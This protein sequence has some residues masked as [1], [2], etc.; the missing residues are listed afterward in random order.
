VYLSSQDDPEVEL[1]HSPSAKPP[2]HGTN[3]ISGAPRKQDTEVNAN[4]ESSSPKLDPK[5]D[6]V[7]TE[8]KIRNNRNGVVYDG[9]NKTNQSSFSKILEKPTTIDHKSFLQT[10]IN[11]VAFKV[12]EWLAPGNFDEPTTS[13]NN[14]NTDADEDEDCPPPPGKLENKQNGT[15]LEFKQNQVVDKVA[16]HVGSDHE[17]NDLPKE[18]S[19]MADSP[20]S[21]TSKSISSGDPILNGDGQDFSHTRSQEIPVP[22]RRSSSTLLAKIPTC[23]PQLPKEVI[24]TSAIINNSDSKLDKKHL[25]RDRRPSQIVRRLSQKEILSSPK[26]ETPPQIS[27]PRTI[28]TPTVQTEPIET[29]DLAPKQTSIKATNDIHYMQDLQIMNQHKQ[30][31]PEPYEKIRLPQSLSHMTAEVMDLICNILQSDGTFERHFLHPP[32]IKDG[33]KHQQRNAVA[34]ARRPLYPK[35]SI[36]PHS[37]RSQWHLFIEQAVFDVFHKPESLLKSFCQNDE[38][39][40]DSQ[41]IWYGMLLMTRAT[42]S[43]VFHGLWVAVGAVF[44][45][46]EDFV[47]KAE[48]SKEQISDVNHTSG[49]ISDINAARIISICLHA[50]V[51]TAP[52]VLG[53]RQLGNMS[54]I[55]SKGLVMDD[56]E[57]PSLCLQYEDAFTNDLAL[58]LARRVFRAIP[59]RQS[60]AESK[61]H[62]QAA[63]GNIDSDLDI[64]Q[65]ILETM[66]TPDLGTLSLFDFSD[67]ESR[68]HEKRVSFLVLDWARTV[69]IHE[70]DGAA[71]IPSNGP[72]GGALAMIAA[73]CTLLKPPY[74]FC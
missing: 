12:V 50:L 21:I 30:N 8:G 73:L 36:Y 20:R 58:R 51:A 52:V 41:S 64:I 72:S 6:S 28:S 22:L 19:E 68:L 18:E 53:E 62:Q 11:T 37:L 70:W 61:R 59:T 65:T 71:E 17:D 35:P 25:S 63:Y 67:S 1:C 60:F 38:V 32:K 74:E 40:W 26:T 69:L 66:R 24:S 3:K 2:A 16:G 27:E 49:A 13:G 56:L 55:R 29:A 14:L 7:I 44:S 43:L 15:K 34:L 33:F 54:R 46:P 10:V 57:L 4:E 23:S 48:L 45:P 47:Y 31:I 42:P 39:L 5:E 9:N